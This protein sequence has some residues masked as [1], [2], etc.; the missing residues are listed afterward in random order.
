MQFPTSEQHQRPPPN[1]IHQAECHQRKRQI[2][3]A[4]NYNVEQNAADSITGPAVDLFRIVENNIDPAPLLQHGQR[5]SDRQ[6]LQNAW[7]QQFSQCNPPSASLPSAAWISA[8]ICAP[9]CSPPMR[10]SIRRACSFSPFFASHRGLS[11]INN[12]VTKKM[13]AGMATTV[14]IHRQPYCP[15]HDLRIISAVAPSGPSRRSAN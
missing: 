9:Y 5:N 15:F 4:G 3:R 6:Y 13:T 11:G 1:S 8:R 14:N 10:A 12:A 7:S 2:D